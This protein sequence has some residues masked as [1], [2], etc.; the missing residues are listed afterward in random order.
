MGAV[1]K[2]RDKRLDRL[3]ALKVLPAGVFADADLKQRFAQEARAA[4]ALNHPHIITI[5]EIGESD[6]IDFIAME[7]VS[8]KA[9][10]QLIPRRGLRLSEAL[11]YSIEIADA[12]AAAHAARIVHRDLKPSNVM[13]SENGTV[14]VLDFGLAKPAEMGATSEFQRTE[15]IVV[16]PDTGEGVILGTVSYMSPEQAQGKKLDT[17]SDIFAFGSVLYEMLTGRRAFQGDSKMSTLAAILNRE[18]EPVG[19]DIP[20]ELARI[21]QRCLRKE[22]ERR[23]QGIADLK[24]AL[25]E[26]KEEIQ[27]GK[28]APQAGNS[29][30]RAWAGILILLLALAGAAYWLTHEK[31]QAPAPLQVAPL[32]TYPG[33][34]DSGS[35][36]PDGNQVAFSWNGGEGDNYDVYVKLIGSGRPLRLTTDPADDIGPAW[37]P[38][39]RSI[40]FVRPHNGGKAEVVLIPALGGSERPVAE[41][42]NGASRPCWSPDG[43]WLVV[44]AKEP[45]AKLPAVFLVS[46]ETGEKR[47]LTF[48]PVTASIRGDETGAI[49]PDKRT[50]AFVRTIASTAADIYLVSLAGDLTATGEPRRLSS[51]NRDIAGIAWSADNREIIFSSNRGGARALWQIAV[52]GGEPRRIA[53]GE[54]GLNP[55]ISAKGDRLVYTRPYSDQNIWRVNL[56][57]PRQPPAQFIASTRMEEGAQYSP[58]GK[59]IAFVSDR[60]GNEE[61]WVCDVDSSNP[62]QLVFMG[63]SGSPHWSPDS[64]RIAFGSDVDGHT[65]IFTVNARGGQPQRITTS[66]SNDAL[67][68]WSHDGKWI[69]FNSNRSGRGQV[70]K[71]PVN[72]GE[73]VQITQQGGFAP[74]ESEDGQTI[75]YCQRSGPGPLMKVPANGGE[76]TQIL[77]TI[78]Y[79]GFAVTRAGIYFTI[80]RELRYLSVATGKSNPILTSEKPVTD[81][82]SVSPD[83]HWLLYT[84]VNRGGSDLMLV[85][86]FR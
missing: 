18:P 27:T 25:E 11:K 6:G 37:S 67:P 32:T 41:F 23:A 29:R 43:R 5:Y 14:K 28:A 16:R 76:E 15:T 77:D 73:P 13:V 48:P 74:L 53:V 30:K 7:F 49:S 52:S 39:G 38:D 54:N 2:A 81:G 72:G 84:Q 64:Q 68:S 51:D 65:Q 9:L 57:G 12:L 40:A 75:Y 66:G 36:S 60:S 19:E 22:P 63:R 4:S 10:D 8:G 1:W 47:Q 17:R 82:L 80:G 55:S 24:L 71:V 86:N 26:L 45:P 70:W 61:V 50:L 35:L 46:V 62:V 31:R 42:P 3:V 44:S 78:R 58:D 85:E 69:Y 33:Y 59:R 34:E 79:R 56:S 83:G 20:P 21:L